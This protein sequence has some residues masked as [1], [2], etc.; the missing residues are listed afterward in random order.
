MRQAADQSLIG[1]SV[2]KSRINAP[3]HEKYVILV[4]P[5]YD[6]DLRMSY[7]ACYQMNCPT[8]HVTKHCAI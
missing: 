6:K 8:F 3:R 2:I 5:S 7:T 1:N 4:M